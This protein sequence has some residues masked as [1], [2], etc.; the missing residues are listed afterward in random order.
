MLHEALDSISIKRFNI[1]AI[2]TVL[3]SSLF[4]VLANIA[5]PN[6]TFYTIKVGEVIA[7][8][9]MPE[10]DVFSFHDGLP[11]TYPHW[12][13]DVAIYYIYHL[14]GFPGLS[15]LTFVLTS[16]LG[17][18][19]YF[20]FVAFYRNQFVALLFAI[21]ILYMFSNG[22]LVPRAQSI[23]Y[24]LFVL[25]LICLMF[26]LRQ[27]S[28]GYL[29][30]L[31]VIAVLIANFHAAVWPFFF[32]LFLPY[33]AEYG[34][35]RLMK[36]GNNLQGNDD[37]HVYQKIVVVRN[38]K[39]LWLIITMGICL[40]SGLLTAIGLTP[41]TY[42]IKTYQ[43]ISVK[44][45]TEHLPLV[46]ISDANFL[47]FFVCSFSLLIF[48]P[49]KLRL[50]ELFLF[51]GMLVLSLMSSRQAM[52][53]YLLGG[54][55]VCRMA[56]EFFVNSNLERV[57]HYTRAMGKMKGR[58]V[59]LIFITLLML[60]KVSNSISGFINP[61]EY[62]VGAT[63]YL[64]KNTDVTQ[65]RPY[66]NYGVG[67][68]LLF[69]GIKVFIDSRADLYTFPFNQ[70]QEI[71]GDSVSLNLMSDYYDDILGKYCMTHIIVEHKEPLNAM[72]SRDSGYRLI[73]S[74]DYNLI[75]ERL[76]SLNN[77]CHLPQ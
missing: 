37:P 68:Y 70:K 29:V 3:L 71:F 60:P 31:F 6:D 50:S 38:D 9:G 77:E 4:I 23:T 2:C 20:S 66:V 33:I 58:I 26:F 28:K 8:Q 36:L 27:G 42:L 57:N 74:D 22:A 10:I 13:Y 59:T 1:T 43:G 64:L 44:F 76:A 18:T 15:V 17:L 30:G 41:Y 48:T 54:F 45:I 35:A 65:I 67:S 40:F 39:V 73:Y 19:L 24:L 75:Y 5:I 47:I 52:L 46:P 55:I 7:N 25:E 72:I 56:T 49:A 11:Y 12:L 14:G 34:I 69:N 53:F 61:E 51:G 62:P 63:S 32:V 21:I 16:T